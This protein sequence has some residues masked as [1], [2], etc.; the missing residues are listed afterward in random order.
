[1]KNKNLVVREALEGYCFLQPK[2]WIPISSLNCLEVFTWE[3]QFFLFLS[4]PTSACHIVIHRTLTLTVESNTKGLKV[5]D[6][7][8]STLKIM[9][10]SL[11]SKEAKMK[12]RIID[13]FLPD[14]TQ[15]A[16]D[17]LLMLTRER[18]DAGCRFR[19]SSENTPAGKET[20]SNKKKIC[21]TTLS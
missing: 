18:K 15:T 10:D 20:K 8:L 17:T 21:Q 9:E 16:S 19:L 14:S 4:C 5:Y 12:Q 2:Q 1:M 7:N 6:Q 13:V 11:L 3:W